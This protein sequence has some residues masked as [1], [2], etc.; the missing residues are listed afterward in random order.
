MQLRQN[1]G[2]FWRLLITP[3]RTFPTNI[4]C[5]SAQVPK[6]SSNVSNIRQLRTCS[7]RYTNLVQTVHYFCKC[8]ASWCLKLTDKPGESERAR[9]YMC[10]C[11][12]KAPLVKLDQD[13]M[14]II[15]P[16]RKWEPLFGLYATMFPGPYLLTK[17]LLLSR[18]K[19]NCFAHYLLVKV[20]EI[21]M[22]SHS[23]QCTRYN[24]SW[25]TYY[26][27]V[28]NSLPWNHE[29]KVVLFLSNETKDTKQIYSKTT[30]NCFCIELTRASITWLGF[31]YS[32]RLAGQSQW[33]DFCC[34]MHMIR[35]SWYLFSP[36]LRVL[37]E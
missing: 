29:S 13:L 20:D 18:G 28:Y 8:N 6:M 33:A 7:Y 16:E 17:K 15:L 30:V 35:N 9:K 22:T 37:W 32:N 26:F 3:K 1:L 34:L 31:S 10:V 11:P 14:L 12:V 27:G 2:L 23:W 36:I 25:S 19:M 21:V 4:L 24:L 5:H